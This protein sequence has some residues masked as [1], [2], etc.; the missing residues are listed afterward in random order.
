[1]AEIINGKNVTSEVRK[2]TA[3][4]AMIPHRLFTFVISIRVALR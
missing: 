2:Q 1:M 4:E 3:L